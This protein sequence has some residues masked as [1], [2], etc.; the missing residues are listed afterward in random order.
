MNAIPNYVLVTVIYILLSP[1]V[2]EWVEPYLYSPSRSSWRGEGQRNRQLFSIAKGLQRYIQTFYRLR[3]K[4]L[5]ARV[6]EFYTERKS[7]KA[8]VNVT[9]E[10]ATK[11]QKESKNIVL[12]FP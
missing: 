5:F 8:K 11:A 1:L 7:L 10:Q 6:S 12:L 4:T 3:P 2:Y 9:L